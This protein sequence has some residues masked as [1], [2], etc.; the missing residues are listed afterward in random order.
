MELQPLTT[1]LNILNGQTQSGSPP[2]GV[3]TQSA[4]ANASHGRARDY[5]LLHFSLSGPLEETAPLLQALT[6]SLAAAFFQT[7]GSVTA[8]LRDAIT[9]INQQ[10]L[11]YNLQAGG[12]VRTGALVCAVL[13]ER[14]LYMAQVGEGLA[15]IGHSFGLE[16]LP[17]HAPPTLTPLGQSAGLDVR[18]THHWLQEGDTLLLMDPRLS[19]LP[20]SAFVPALVQAR[21]N[22]RVEGLTS[23]LAQQSARLILVEFREGVRPKQVA[24]EPTITLGPLIAPARAPVRDPEYI[25]D[26]IRAHRR[27]MLHTIAQR[28]RAA[29]GAAAEAEA[30]SPADIDD[31]D[32]EENEAEPTAGGSG[33]TRTARQGA[34]SV[35]GGLSRLTGG[36]AR[37]LARLREPGSQEE[38]EMPAER[39]VAAMLAIIVPI[40]IAVIVAGVYIQ[41]GEV[42][43]LA[44]LRLESKVALDNG[45]QAERN[46]EDARPYYLQVL[47][48][49]DEADV[50]RPDDPEIGRL[51]R[52]ASSALDRLQGITRLTGQ[53]M[54]QFGDSAELTSLVLRPGG[55]VYILDSANNRLQYLPTDDTYMLAPEVTPEQLLTTND[56]VA[57]HVVGKI[58]DLLWRPQGLAVS[59]DGVAALDA[60]G[61][62]VTYHPAFV[63][64]RAAPLDLASQWR[65]PSAMA[66]Y[67]ERIYILDPATAQIWRYL[68][69]GDGFTIES[70]YQSIVLNDVAQAVDMSFYED[71]SIILAY[72][73][74]HVRRYD[75]G[76]ELWNETTL[77]N[78]G[79]STPLVAPRAVKV[80]G[81]GLN[82]SI[83]IADPGSARIVQVSLAGVVL[84]EYKATT[85]D[86]QELF[87][88]VDD[89][90]VLETPL[91]LLVVGGRNLLLASM[92]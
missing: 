24:D 68:P 36:L 86:G 6:T 8:A 75:S 70:G 47:R 23:L 41:R 54:Y 77:L 28:E 22:R 31:I 74:G 76:R 5:L 66:A 12:V 71:G 92:P 29:T 78:N 10:L 4:P 14:E 7:G 13:R 45:Q 55:G 79:L 33:L 83:F 53:T 65:Q 11:R 85:E 64:R 19:Y 49:A 2:P 30:A 80:S 73:N 72:Q 50:I 18:Y 59:Q 63:T 69:N 46:N 17:P 3:F 1:P 88:Q 91:R 9:G 15:L 84:A 38:P 27:R 52:Q 21:G 35:I 20:T 48:L 42:S 43:R 37:L 39:A 89:F 44:E 61:A 82:S 90:A 87:S 32:E 25:V 57:S 81:S 58:V 34:A 62:I 56:V 16:R 26:E 40:L 60:S 51:R 67:L